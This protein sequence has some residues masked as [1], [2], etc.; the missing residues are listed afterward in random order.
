MNI[1]EA[2]SHHVPLPPELKGKGTD[3]P[4][5]WSFPAFKWYVDVFKKLEKWDD[6]TFHGEADVSPLTPGVGGPE[7]TSVLIIENA[8]L[9]P[10][11]HVFLNNFFRLAFQIREDIRI[12]GNVAGV[13][14]D[15]MT[16][17]DVV[18]STDLLFIMHKDDL[19]N[20]QKS[21]RLSGLFAEMGIKY[22]D[23]V[24]QRGKYYPQELLGYYPPI[25]VIPDFVGAET[26]DVSAVLTS[27]AC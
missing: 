6:P 21:V 19:V 23:D 13:V 22:Y 8:P 18:V 3:K 5:L 4:P 7:Y 15:G 26:M 10:S 11:E 24:I 2:L 25:F 20:I 16:A 1:I 9:R 17:D 12:I 14:F 27:D